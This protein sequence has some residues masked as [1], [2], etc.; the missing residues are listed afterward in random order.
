MKL[1]LKYTC[2]KCGATNTITSFWRWLSTP[3]FGNRK[4]LRCRECGEKNYM[5]RQ[6]WTGPKWLDWPKDW[7][8]K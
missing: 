3:H 7:N 8:K 1:N 2:R 6:G 4:L 5:P